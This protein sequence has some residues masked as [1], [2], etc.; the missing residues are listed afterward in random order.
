VAG[1]CA[2]CVIWDL[3][4]GCEVDGYGSACA[5]SSVANT[6][7]STFSDRKRINPPSSVAYAGRICS[8][9][10][11][12]QCEPTMGQ[13]VHRFLVLPWHDWLDNTDKLVKILAVIV[14]G[15]WAYL[16]F[17]KGRVYHPRL[18]PS[19]ALRHFRKGE[20]DYLIVTAVLKNIGVSKIDIQKEGTAVRLFACD[21]LQRGRSARLVK[22][23]R[24]R[25]VGVF[26]EHGWIEAAERIEDS[27]IFRLPPNQTAIRVEVRVVAKGIQWKSHA[28]IEIAWTGNSTMAT[29]E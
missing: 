11:C 16:R 24:L 4:L 8:N 21:E 29:A 28:V 3:A 2:G 6:I 1:R 18:E 17:F 5:P 23:G 27:M 12:F 15:T 22:W 9:I 20:L 19:L 14:G 7:S 13:F 26:E 25:T 10:H